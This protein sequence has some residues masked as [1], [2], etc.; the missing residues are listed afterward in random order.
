MD[1]IENDTNNNNSKVSADGSV[2]TH[3][4]VT[5]AGSGQIITALERT[6]LNTIQATVNERNKRCIELEF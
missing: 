4:D 5:N 1:Q 2:T 3:S 6:A